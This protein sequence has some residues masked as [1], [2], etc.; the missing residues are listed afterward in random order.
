MPA[1]RASNWADEFRDPAP[2]HGMGVYWWWF[3]PAVTKVEVDRELDV[4][5]RAGIGSVLI[6]PV[7]PISVDNPQL[8]IKNLRYLSP[9]FLEVLGHA[10]NKAR[11]LDLR[12][13][14]VI[15]TGWPF[16]GPKVTPE[17]GA[18]RLRIETVESPPGGSGVF[19]S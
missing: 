5:H 6:F 4:M 18:R 1:L 14:L 17:L 7:Y 12:A 9:E 8:G 2:S 15:G 13:D 10:V 19:R 3:G 11:E 16:V